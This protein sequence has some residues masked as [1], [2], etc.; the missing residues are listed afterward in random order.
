MISRKEL[1]STPVWEYQTGFDEKFN[2][3]L[4]REINA[5]SNMRN[6]FQNN[7]WDYAN[8]RN[9]TIT[10]L[11]ETFLELVSHTREF[12]PPNF[13]FN[14][15]FSRAWVSRQEPGQALPIH[16]HGGTLI[17]CVYYISAPQNAGDLLLIDPRGSVNWGWLSDGGISGIKYQRIKPEVGKMVMFP[18][19]VLHSVEV[20]RSTETRISLATNI[21]NPPKTK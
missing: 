6:T 4:L 2:E 1:W 13:T 14:P 20:N 21:F 8:I 11:R 10:K 12:F 17:S 7:I 15:Q 18:A 9:P 16:D 19:Y 3:D 5:L